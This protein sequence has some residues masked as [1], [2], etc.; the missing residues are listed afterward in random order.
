M[1][2]NKWMVLCLIICSLLAV[3]TI[4]SMPI[5]SNSI[6]QRMLIKDLES[7]QVENNKYPGRS[8]SFTT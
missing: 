2:R 4:S 1:L 8:Q 5:Y 3:S 6:F 7:Y